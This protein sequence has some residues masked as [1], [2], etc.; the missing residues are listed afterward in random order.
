MLSRPRA[1]VPDSGREG[2]LRAQPRVV[3]CW[4]HL[5]VALGQASHSQLRD[6]CAPKSRIPSLGPRCKSP[7]CGKT[8]PVIPWLSS[9]HLPRGR[10]GDLSDLAVYFLARPSAHKVSRAPQ[11]LGRKPPRPTQAMGLASLASPKPPCASAEP[12]AAVLLGTCRQAFAQAVPS[13]CNALPCLFPSLAP[14]TSSGREVDASSCRSP[15]LMPQVRTAVWRGCWS[16]CCVPMG[17][18]TNYSPQGMFVLMNER[19]PGC[20][21]C[22]HGQRRVKGRGH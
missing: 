4:R 2:P 3:V 1:G 12:P 8:P 6:G 20:T 13:A 7:P 11:G 10:R 22:L 17:R 9:V 16:H 21:V 19:R 15:S 18:D 5:V 14:V